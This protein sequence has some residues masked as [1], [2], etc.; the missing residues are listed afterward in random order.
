MSFL[1]DLALEAAGPVINSVGSLIGMNTSASKQMDLQKDLMQYQWNNF[2]SPT[3]QVKELAKAGINPA[4][5]FGNG[6]PSMG[7]FNQAPA[8]SPPS[9]G[10]GTTSLTELAYY[11]KSLADAKKA[12]V[13][14]KVGEEEVKNKQIERQV[15]EFNLDIQKAFGKE[16]KSVE[17]AQAY[18]NLLL[19]SDTHDLN[20][21]DKAIRTYKQEAEKAISTQEG[22]KAEMLRQ[23]MENNPVVI[24]LEN[25]L[26]EEKSKTER[27]QQSVNYASA[28]NQSSQADQNEIFN[29]IYSDKRYGHSLITQ[30]V[31]A[32]RQA[33]EQSRIS[34]SQAEHMN[35]LVEQAAFA[36]DM[37]EFTYWSEQIQGF[38]HS[39]GEAAS[40]FYGAG[41]LRELINLR[42]AQQ[43][44]PAPIKGFR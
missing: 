17:L 26:L 1:G 5:A 22:Y 21:L 3:A 10:I 18:R 9:F 39:I 40:S 20:E 16:F 25:E 13:D 8:L 31:E 44:K 41:A 28:K 12:G 14:T 23:R 6:A 11:M 32:G 33:V 42:Q 15:M 24:R 29:K 38:V 7:S 27:S 4:V 2:Q 43:I 34:K 35:Y 36:N 30:A 19:L 37:K